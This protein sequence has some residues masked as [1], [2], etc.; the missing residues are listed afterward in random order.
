MVY[1][2]VTD[3]VSWTVG[4]ERLKLCRLVDKVLGLIM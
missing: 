2:T 4:T 1:I 3:S